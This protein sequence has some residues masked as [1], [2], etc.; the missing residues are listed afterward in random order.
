MNIKGQGNSL[1]FIQGHSD[2]TFSNFFC[3]ETTWPIEA[4]FHMEPPNEHLFKRSR[5]HD[6]AH[7]W[8]KTSKNVFGTKGHWPWTLVYSIGY[9]STTNVFIWWPWVDWPFSRQG[10]FCFQ[11]LLH[12]WKLIQHRVLMYFQVCSNSAYPQHSGEQYRTNG[13]LVPFNI[14]KSEL[15]Y[16]K[17]LKKK[18]ALLPHQTFHL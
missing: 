2:S 16:R 1:T 18:T 13:P 14:K 6:H 3:S 9:L 17:N 5:S 11:M 8:W 12:G 15:P 10:Q 7:I 4:R